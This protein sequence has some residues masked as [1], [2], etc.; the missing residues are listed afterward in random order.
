MC[1]M[2]EMCGQESWRLCIFRKSGRV[3]SVLTTLLY[4][5]SPQSSHLALIDTL[6][7][8]YTVE[9]MSVER[10]M[11]CIN[12]YSSAEPSHS[13]RHIQELPY[14]TEDAIITWINKVH[15]GARLCTH[16]S[17]RECVFTRITSEHIL[18]PPTMEHTCFFVLLRIWKT[19]EVFERQPE[20]LQNLNGTSHMQSCQRDYEDVSDSTQLPLVGYSRIERVK[21]DLKWAVSFKQTVIKSLWM[22]Q[23]IW[24]LKV[25]LTNPP[26]DLKGVLI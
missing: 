12:R 6:M 7:M 8:A 11:S 16:K 18:E 14:D 26:G 3:Q 22:C 5:I 24:T 20:L 25:A 13:D 15:P 2:T 9:M 21:S 17:T 23:S 1:R 10:V 4:C 19:W